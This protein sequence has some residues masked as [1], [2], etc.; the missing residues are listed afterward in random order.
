[1]QRLLV[2][3]ISLML[4]ASWS[5]TQDD[6]EITV[7]ATEEVIFVSGEKIRVVGRLITNQA[8]QATD[9]GFQLSESESF[10]N[11]TVISLGEKDGPGRFIGETDGLAIR[12]NYFVRAFVNVSGVELFGQTIATETLSPSID[13]FSPL[14]SGP[15]E[16]LTII[17]RNFTADTRVFFGDVEATVLDID[18]ESRLKVRIPEFAGKVSTP[19]I[20]VSQDERLE[21]T[22]PFEYRTGKYTLLAQFPEAERIYDNVY[23]QDQ[24]AFYFGLGSIRSGASL[25]SFRRFDPQSGTWSS[26]DFPGETRK[27]SFSAG[28]YIGGGADVAQASFTYKRDFWKL[29]GNS[30]ERLADIPTESFHSLA[31]E[32]NGQLF[33]AGGG[34][35]PRAIH[36]YDPGSNAWSTQSVSPIEF[37]SNMTTFTYQNKAYFMDSLNLIWEYEPVSD[38]WSKFT[39]M[40]SSVGT[41]FG[42]A[43]VIGDKVYIGLFSRSTVMM[44][45]DM[46]TKTWKTKNPIPGLAASLNAGAFVYQDQLYLLR[47]PEKTVPGAPM[48]F[49]R[50]EPDGF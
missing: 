15:G 10:S 47:T 46:K 27:G 11:P 36:K 21:S 24:N 9:H 7:V 43:Q 33:Y 48:E 34:K 42:I 26:L 23:F 12:H 29:N 45:L 18:F 16:E 30:F 17:G 28:G 13:S 22:Q 25:I 3:C 4:L 44:E 20:V 40:P 38:S 31:F 6:E 41:A 8:L 50:F 19:L 35:D 39:E 1:M 49:Y 14:L 32:A 5:C 37:E 2:L